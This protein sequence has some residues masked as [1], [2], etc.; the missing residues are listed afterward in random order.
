MNALNDPYAAQQRLLQG[1]A[2]A[3]FV[4]FDVG[5]H[6][7]TTVSRYRSLFPHA[8][9]YA[10]EAC[11][12]SVTELQKKF[13]GDAAI[14]IVPRAVADRPGTRTFY[15]N[16]RPATNSL[17]PRPVATRRYFPSDAGPRST[18]EVSATTLDEFTDSERIGAVHI[19]KFDIQGGELMALRGAVRLLSQGRPPIVFSEVLFV[20]LYE[21][22]A[23]FCELSAHLGEYGYA[24]YGLYDLNFAANGQLRFGDAIFVSESF[25]R[26]VLDRFPDEP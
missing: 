17:L 20:P 8:R 22:A 15:V 2:L 19:L 13:R 3:D 24:L 12:E 16:G 7:G 21:G 25:R 26:D 4:I 18:I 10:F 1:L 5:A 9:I 23:L 14:R 6:R 11:P